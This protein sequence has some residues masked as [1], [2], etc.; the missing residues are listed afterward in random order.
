[1][2]KYIIAKLKE[3]KRKQGSRREAISKTVLKLSLRFTKSVLNTEKNILKE[4][5]DIL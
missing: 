3:K 2:L 5:K 1:M 4:K